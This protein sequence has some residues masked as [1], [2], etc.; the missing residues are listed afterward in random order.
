MANP[1]VHVELQTNDPAGAKKFYSSLFGWK[2]QDVPMAGGMTYTMIDVGGG[3]GGGMLV[4]P[5]PGSAVRPS[6][7]STTSPTPSST[8]R[9]NRSGRIVS[10]FGFGVW[11]CSSAMN[12][13]TSY[14]FVRFERVSAESCR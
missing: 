1:F 7:R 10:R 4:N 2:L 14:V 6:L 12:Q 3:T 9:I 11:F 5:V 8:R 13:N